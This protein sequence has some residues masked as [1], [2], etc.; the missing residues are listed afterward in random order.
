MLPR[1]GALIAEAA[2][3]PFRGPGAGQALIALAG[4]SPPAIMTTS[5]GAALVLALIQV[6]ISININFNR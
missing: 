1:I 5:G 4:A 3:L 6:E 2:T